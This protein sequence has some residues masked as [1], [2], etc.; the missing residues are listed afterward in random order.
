LGIVRPDTSLTRD[1][2]DRGGG[3]EIRT[4]VDLPIGSGLGTSSILAAAVVRALGAML[5]LEDTSQ[6]LS[7]RVMLVEQ[8]MTTGGG[9]QDQ[10]GGIFPGA[11]LISS[12][13]GLQQRIRVR[14]LAW[15]G[16]VQDEFSRRL[17]L[18]YTGIR[19][20][21]KGLL[22]Q[23]VGSYLAR[24]TSTVQVL[25]S[26]KTLAA[27]MACA[28]EEADWTYAGSLMNRHWSLNQLLDPNTT[29]APINA[30]LE[31][32]APFVSGAKLAGAGGGGFLILL[33]RDPECT[34][35]LRAS[36]ARRPEGAVYRFRIAGQ[37]LHVS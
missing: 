35:R 32:V 27:E 25:H 17:V 3:L 36:L 34:D 24:E 2:I 15:S 13:P 30:L 19:R 23:V 5:G 33:A 21:A 1:L 22:E 7:D 10:A 16:A 4:A 12:G 29:N 14:P 18:Y 31:D 6:Q 8:R 9:W 28:L 37:G 20:I 11:K 26:I